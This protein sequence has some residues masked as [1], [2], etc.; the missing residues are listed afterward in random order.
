MRSVKQIRTELIDLLFQFWFVFLPFFCIIIISVFGQFCVNGG[1][2]NTIFTRHVIKICAALVML[3][4]IALQDKKIWMVYSYLAYLLVLA[5]LICVAIFGV[6]RL[7]AKRWIDMHFIVIQP[8]EMMKLVLILALAKYYSAFSESELSDISK[9]YFPLMLVAIPLALILKQPDLGTAIL[10]GFVGCS[11]VFVSGF[12][13]K[14]I[15]YALFVVIS[16]LPIIWRYLKPYQQNRVLTFLNPDR[17]PLGTGYHILQSK[18]AVGSGGVFGKGFLKGTQSSLD[19]LPE[20]NTDFIFTALGEENGF[21]G[22]IVIITLF[23]ALISGLLFL[24]LNSKTQ[25][26][27]YV[28][29]GCAMMIFIHAFINISMVIGMVPVVGVPIPFISYG[30][31]SLITCTAAIGIAISCCRHTH[32]G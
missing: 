17:D 32:R 18:I 31:S 19:F 11:I 23:F 7:G 30:G 2:I 1:E 20:K 25:F 6:T 9:H 16:S 15:L 28:C 21:I 10:V 13:I 29:V 26:G 14:Y 27:R 22:S 3:F 12:R 5:M 4:C 8:S 24:S